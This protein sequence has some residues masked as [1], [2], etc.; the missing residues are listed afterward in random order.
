MASFYFFEGR[1]SAKEFDKLNQLLTSTVNLTWNKL[2]EI[3]LHSS[4]DAVDKKFCPDKPVFNV[5]KMKLI[6]LELYFIHLAWTLVSLYFLS[7]EDI[8]FTFYDGKRGYTWAEHKKYLDKTVNKMV[9]F[10]LMRIE[11]A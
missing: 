9:S 6:E 3:Y 8:Q 5:I 7:W 1:E 2:C 10:S 4:T 11:R